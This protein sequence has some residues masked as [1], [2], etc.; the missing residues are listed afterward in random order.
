MT[1]MTWPSS[2]GACHSK[3]QSAGS[4][5]GGSQL[6][7]GFSVVG[8]AHRRWAPAAGRIPD[9]LRHRQRGHVPGRFTIVPSGG[10]A[11]RPPREH[12]CKGFSPL[13]TTH[14]H[15]SREER[16]SSTP[17]SSSSQTALGATLYYPKHSHC[18]RTRG[19]ISPE[20]PKPGYVSC[21]FELVLTP[22][23]GTHRRSHGSTH[24]K[25]SPGI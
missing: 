20:S 12:P 17:S 11:I 2:A 3:R 18:S 1:R 4:A 15:T 22:A 7:A 10:R 14:T 13:A 6:S 21:A 25:P 19:V 23:S 9:S 24:D 8:G 5:G 16:E